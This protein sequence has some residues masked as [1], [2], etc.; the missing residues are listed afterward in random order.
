MWTGVGT[1]SIPSSN[2]G[3]ST[4][5]CPSLGWL[6]MGRQGE[7]RPRDP[8]DVQVMSSSV[9]GPGRNLGR[10]HWLSCPSPR[11]RPAWGCPTVQVLAVGPHFG[12]E[13]STLTLLCPCLSVQVSVLHV[14]LAW[15]A[16]SGTGSGR[17]PRQSMSSACVRVSPRPAV[18]QVRC[19]SLELGPELR[20]GRS[21]VPRKE[22]SLK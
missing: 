14:C 10:S 22:T 5:S 17:G 3:P 4:A 13:D 8:S 6:R 1:L 21:G 7:G 11:S 15:A 19:C 12:R 9:L 18:R 2:P 16:A 20:G